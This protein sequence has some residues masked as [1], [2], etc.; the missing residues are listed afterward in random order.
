MV[1]AS[2]GF[3]CPE[4][5]HSGAKQQR[6]VEVYRSATQP[7]VTY[8]LLAINVAVYV[9][10]A[11]FGS[12]LGGVHYADFDTRFSLWAGIGRTVDGSQVTTGVANGEWWRIITGGFMHASPLHIAFNMFALWNVGTAL[13]RMIGRLRFGLIYAVSLLGGSLG[14]LLF[15]NPGGSTVGASGAIFGLFGA[16]VLLQLSRGINPMQGGIAMTIG[17]NLVLTFTIPGISAGGHIGGL[18]VGALAGY[19]LIGHNIRAAQH[20]ETSLKV[21]A[22]IVVGLCIVLFVAS[23][24]AAHYVVLH[25][26][27]V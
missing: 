17:I 6:L 24:Y 5:A 21:M 16:L 4:C 8:V 20:R 23:I 14:A 9:V 25:G 3:Q 26:A 18:L 10:G 2:V 1:T 15:S 19:V 11:A 22:P 27:L 7:R 13:E 12:K